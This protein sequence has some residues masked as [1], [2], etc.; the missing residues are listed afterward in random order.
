MLTGLTYPLTH[1]ETWSVL[2]NI[3]RETSNLKKDKAPESKLTLSE[4]VRSNESMN[5]LHNKLR[6]WMDASSTLSLPFDTAKRVTYRDDIKR[7]S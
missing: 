2:Y 4:I 5:S 3:I 6:Q 1:S 7:R